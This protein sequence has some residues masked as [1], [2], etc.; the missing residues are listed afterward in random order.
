MVMKEELSVKFYF[1][2]TF[3]VFKELL[4]LVTSVSF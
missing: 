3:F 1:E 2:F 4:D